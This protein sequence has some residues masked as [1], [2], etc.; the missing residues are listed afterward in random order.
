MKVKTENQ[1]RKINQCKIGFHVE[2]SYAAISQVGGNEKGKEQGRS[3][4]GKSKEQKV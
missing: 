4:S 3:R 2:L 1:E